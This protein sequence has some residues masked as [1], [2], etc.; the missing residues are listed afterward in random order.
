MHHHLSG[1]DRE[2]HEW[3]KDY[4]VEP[5]LRLGARQEEAL[6]EL[7]EKTGRDRYELLDEAVDDLIDKY[8]RK[9]STLKP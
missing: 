8:R 6:A 5:A 7:P 9:S 3:F 2:L 1:G 4:R